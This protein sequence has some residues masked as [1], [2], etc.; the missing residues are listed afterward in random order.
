MTFQIHL[1]R[2]PMSLP[3]GIPPGCGGNANSKMAKSNGR[4]EMTVHR[5]LLGANLADDD[6]KTTFL[7]QLT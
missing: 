7:Q 3:T 5:H 2:A 6:T 1:R 4:E